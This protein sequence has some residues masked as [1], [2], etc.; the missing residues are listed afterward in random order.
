M[1]APSNAPL[2]QKPNGRPSGKTNRADVLRAFAA[3][4]NEE[5]TAVEAAVGRAKKANAEGVEHAVHAGEILI[6][7][8][9]AVG[10]GNWM[11]WTEE[12]FDGSHRTVDLYMHL[13]ER[14][15]EISQGLANLGIEAVAKEL[16]RPTRNLPEVVSDW[17]ARR[18]EFMQRA[19]RDVLDLAVVVEHAIGLAPE[20]DRERMNEE[21][22]LMAR[23]VRKFV[24]RPWPVTPEPAPTL[25]EDDET[26][27]AV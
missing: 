10:H 2:R 14:K 11:R 3:K 26:P 27:E 25:V 17:P 15:A 1:S 12:N 23:E 20:A 18:G 16:A 21:R 6:A 13:A 22:D 24:A 5:H 9:K 7:A 4:A 19:I 8:K